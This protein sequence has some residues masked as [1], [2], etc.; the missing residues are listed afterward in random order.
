[1]EIGRRR[2][3]FAT[4][5]GCQ[6]N[7]IMGLY[8]NPGNGN[9]NESVNS[10]IYVDKSM[11]LAELNSLIGTSDKFL[12]VSRPRRFGKTM[13]ESMMAAYYSRGCDSAELFKGLK[14]ADD[15]SFFKHLNKY[16]VLHLDIN[17]FWS[18]HKAEALVRMREAV[19]DEFRE[20][21]PGAVFGDSLTIA[22]C[23][24]RAYKTTGIPFVIILD[25]YDVIFRDG[26][27]SCLE[28][29][30]L[31]LLNALFK[32]ADV[33]S[34]IAL[35]YITGILPIIRD[36]AQS[37]LNNFD[38]V[39]FLEP[40]RFAPYTGFTDDEVRDL[41]G[42]YGM[43]YVECR[44]WYDGYR[45]EGMDIYAPRS[46][47]SAMVNKR[48]RSY[49]NRTS[50]FKV[51]REMVQ[52][53]FDGMLDDVKAM[54]SSLSIPVNITRF[55]NSPFNIESKDDAFT[56]LCH[57]GYLS[58]DS[59]TGTCRIPNREVRE[60]WVSSIND[61]PDYATVM[62]LINHSK[63]VLEA[64]WAMDC[65]R[66]AEALERSHERLAS[67]LSYNNEQSLQSAIRLA[68]F[69]ADC[70]Y[71]IVMEYPA[72]KGYADMA[73]IPYKPNI[74]AMLV[75]LKVKGT[76]D[77][78]LEQIR[79]RRYFAG[80]EKYQGNTLLVGVS[81]DKATKRHECVIERA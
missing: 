59:M 58:Y 38:E 19:L 60:E 4:N 9:F 49:W 37:K 75:E 8:V 62:E 11:L 57:L 70:Y 53:N 54:I 17:R 26:D 79:E 22:D 74:P 51:V 42:K 68:L 61:N 64:T 33:T 21:F 35:A 32:G 50:T 23:V 31:K 56:Y 45:T 69:Y 27:A 2:I 72:G 12:A 40:M 14:M 34:C 43:D 63:G 15:P 71:T 18:D 29:E 3:S 77:T 44:G 78:A 20:E 65:A 41:C 39:T 47:V 24:T 28:D 13:A 80:L 10:R 16:N 46:V 5:A 76:A 7:F 48:F 81:Y 66:F 55:D 1:M 67:S 73:F 36:K 30:Y 6:Y 52:M 25:E